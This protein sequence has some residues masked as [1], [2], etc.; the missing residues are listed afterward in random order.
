[1]SAA[2]PACKSV[3]TW[4]SSMARRAT[5]LRLYMKPT[6]SVLCTPL[7][8]M[9][10]LTL[11]MAP[12]LRRG[13]LVTDVGSVKGSVVRQVEP[14]VAAAG[15]HFVGSHPMAGSE[16]MGARAAE[17]NLFSNAVCVITPAGNSSRTRSLG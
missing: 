13:A 6:W 4:E 14:L 17:P 5:W 2:P 9:R 3:W 12:G 1:M 15:A 16:R 10:E 8:Q 7:A 11:G